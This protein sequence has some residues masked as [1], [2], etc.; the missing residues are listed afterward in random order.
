VSPVTVPE[1]VVL[2]SSIVTTNPL[3]AA[4]TVLASA[5]LGFFVHVGWINQAQ[6]PALAGAL[7]VL[8]LAAWRWQVSHFRAKQSIVLANA[9]PNNV[10]SVTGKFSEP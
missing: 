10:A 7:V 1:P 9:A 3:Y 2:P 8:G 4:L 5:G 6:V